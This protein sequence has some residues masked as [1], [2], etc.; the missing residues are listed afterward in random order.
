MLDK[1]KISPLAI[2]VCQKLQQVGYQSYL[3]GGSVRDLLLEVAP[4]DWD[5]ATNAKPE[6]TKQIF[7][8]TY[9]TGIAHGTITV[10]MGETVAD[11]FEVTTYRTEG[12][13]SDGRRPDS[14]DFVN[15]IELD[16]ARRDL[17]INAMAYDP[18]NDQLVDPYGGA[19]D[20]ADKLIRAVGNPNERFA[21]DGLRIMRVARF[22][23]RFGYNVSEYTLE[24][25]KQSLDTL[26][27]VSKER[28]SDELSKTLMSA[29][30]SLGLEILLSTGALYVACPL[31]EG[32][33]LPLLS[34][35]DKCR[36]ELETRLA[37]LFNKLDIVKVKEQLIDLKFSNKEINKVILLFRIWDLF[38]TTQLRQKSPQPVLAFRYF[39]SYIKNESQ[40]NWEH[41]LSEF[42]KLTELFDSSVVDLLDK[43]RK[44]ICFARRE[45]QVNGDDLIAM[46]MKPGKQIKEKLDM[47]YQRVLESP[48]LNE[49]EKLL[50][51]INI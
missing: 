26:K 6:Q 8:K 32:R 35:Q 18:I 20:L 25:M 31:L 14:V 23:A 19:K 40:E 22:A 30:P 33:Q 43:Y 51:L 7:D 48:D 24:G 10:S 9:D 49:K 38:K 16:L 15:E 42:I 3:V 37:L 12:K 27:R 11:H 39:I 5:I 21:E 4:K 44:E 2:E 28:I 41:T 13:Y 46:G 29:N 45:L 34:M 17:T 1:L 50:K 36:G 47:L